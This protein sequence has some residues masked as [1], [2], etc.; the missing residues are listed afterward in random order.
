M[1]ESLHFISMDNAMYDEVQDMVFS[2]PQ[3]HGSLEDATVAIT[4]LRY[5]CPIWTLNFRDFSIFNNL[6][7]WNP[8]P[9]R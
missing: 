6:E 5:R 3:W 7:F 9:N 4:A 1:N 2:L 8:D